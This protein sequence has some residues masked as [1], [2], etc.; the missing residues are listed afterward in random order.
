MPESK[1]PQEKEV[2]YLPGADVRHHFAAIISV[3]QR[4]MIG[5]ADH[6]LQ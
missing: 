1:T 6:S 2:A 4:I 5:S 3:F